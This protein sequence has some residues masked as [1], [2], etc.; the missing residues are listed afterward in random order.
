MPTV[1]SAKQFGKELRPPARTDF[2]HPSV[3]CA[4]KG[5][6]LFSVSTFKYCDYFSE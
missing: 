1:I 5:N 6:L 3:L 2:H 4:G